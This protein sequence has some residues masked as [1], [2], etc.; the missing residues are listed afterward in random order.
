M[1]ELTNAIDDDIQ[2]V[3]RIL[4]TLAVVSGVVMVSLTYMNHS[5]DNV[6]SFF[7]DHN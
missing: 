6:I 1:A 2:R 4:T 7:D 3:N 5:S